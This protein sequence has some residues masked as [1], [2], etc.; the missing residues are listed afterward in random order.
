MAGC[1]RRLDEERKSEVRVKERADSVLERQ[2]CKSEVVENSG[3]GGGL[4]I[5]TKIMIR[6]VASVCDLV[7]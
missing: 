4:P 3:G 5:S 1:T 6:A 2:D 7:R